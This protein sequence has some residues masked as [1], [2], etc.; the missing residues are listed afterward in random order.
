ML[1]E[2][3]DK[4]RTTFEAV[5]DGEATYEEAAESLH[6]PVGTVRS[7]VS[8]VRAAVRSEYGN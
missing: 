2:M 1:N 6:I 8:R 5:L 3:P 4:I 7:R